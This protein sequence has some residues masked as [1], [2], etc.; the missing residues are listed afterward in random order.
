MRELHPWPQVTINPITA[1]K[2][3]IQNGQWVWIENDRGRFRQVAKVSNIVSE[4]TVHA[5]HGWWFPEQEPE[6]PYLF[7]TFDSN[8]NNCTRAF[9]VGQGGVGSS[10]K[11][12]ICKIYPCQEEDQLPGEKICLEGG[13]NEV[14][15]GKA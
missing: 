3:G 9:V 5:E 2:Y 7:G 10:I 1:E 11:S 15:P 13:F 8:P 14:V 12:M 6:P 4:Q